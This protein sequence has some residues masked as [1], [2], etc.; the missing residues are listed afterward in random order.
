MTGQNTI[1]D[2]S[3]GSSEDSSEETVARDRLSR[4]SRS[5]AGKVAIVTGAASGMGRATAY[6]FA[7]EGARVVV[8]DIGV[9]RVDAVVHEIAAVHG[10]DT[11]LGVV[12]DVAELDELRSLVDRTIEWAGRLD[13]VVNN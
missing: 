12:C 2:N 13:I 9:E 4:L 10:T 5:V 8:A 11:V 6:L 1:P 7:D 3:R